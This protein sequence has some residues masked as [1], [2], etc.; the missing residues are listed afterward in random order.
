MRSN[1]SIKSNQIHIRLVIWVKKRSSGRSWII[2]DL[3]FWYI[4]HIIN[5][6]DTTS[7]VHAI[8]VWSTITAFRIHQILSL[9]GSFSHVWTI[10]FHAVIWYLIHSYD[11]WPTS[12]DAT[13]I[14]SGY[15]LVSSSFIRTQ[16]GH[17]I[18]SLVS[19][20]TNVRKV[21]RRKLTALKD[22]LRLKKVDNFQVIFEPKW[23]PNCTR[24]VHTCENDAK[25][26][27]LQPDFHYAFVGEMKERDVIRKIKTNKN[28]GFYLKNVYDD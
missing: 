6:S 5:N 20:C 15:T 16:I 2:P 11:N 28:K 19:I 9:F 22:S 13:L 24:R 17:M 3:V 4:I 10:I 1:Y 12:L 25:G 26:E 27:I 14:H 21:V 18:I 7:L 23:S 8:T